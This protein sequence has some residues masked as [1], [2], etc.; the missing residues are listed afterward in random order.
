MKFIRTET[1]KVKD[2]KVNTFVR[3]ELN[4]D[5]ALYLADLI[6]GGV[7]MREKVK[8]TEE[9][10]I[11][12][13]RHRK[14]AYE[15]ADVLEI[16]VE[17]YKVDSETDLIAAGFRANT[18]GSMPPSIADTEHT[19]A[20]LLERGV[21]MRAIGELLGLPGNIARKYAGSVKSRLDRAKIVKAGAAVTD[22]NLTV[23][24][25]AQQ[26]DVP[27]EK[28]KEFLSG[29]RKKRG[30]S[31][32][33]TQRKLTSQYKSIGQRNAAFCRN[34]IE[35]FEDGDLKA[36]EVNDIFNH[37]QRLAD[38]SGRVLADWRARF[39]AKAGIELP[40]KKSEKVAKAS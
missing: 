5:H 1:V 30:N 39:A 2:I 31:L 13:G 9:H 10:L 22:G 21:S 37:L 20:L 34:L 24:K 6:I 4:H 7:K 38:R 8:L 33:D 28:L 29:T 16:E 36:G 32:A 23:A 12:D 14:E 40:S 11:I 25:A 3:Q 26:F 15:L 27:P 18:G 19:I 17:I 35:K